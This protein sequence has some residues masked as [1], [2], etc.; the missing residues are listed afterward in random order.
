MLFSIV[1]PTCNRNDLLSECLDQLTAEYQSNIYFDYEVIVS[2]DSDKGVA[3]KLIAEKYSW[4]KW[5]AGPQKGPAAN[6]N[7]GAWQAK[8]DWIVFLDDDCLPSSKILINYFNI[9]AANDDANVVEGLIYSDDVIPPLYTAPVNTTGGHL[10]S[11]NFGIQKEV[12][13]KLNGFDENYKYPNLE[14]ND[15]NKRLI[16]GG[17][18]I[19]FGK[20]AKVYHAPR[21]VASPEKY[22][23]Y[24]ESWLYYHKKIWR[25]KNSER[26]ID[27]YIAE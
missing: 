4:V 18:K 23:R 2:D 26:F 17:Y 16:Q 15:L 3:Q 5:L 14:D 7:N 19:V 21:P 6:R 1:I 22:A 8:G 24:H 20:E 10:W 27:N 11:C 13:K 9:I 25:R 12:F